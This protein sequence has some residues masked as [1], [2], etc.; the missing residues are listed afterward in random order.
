MTNKSNV[1]INFDTA[2]AMLSRSVAA[3]KEIQEVC[4]NL[5]DEIKRIAKAD[6]YDTGKYE[7][8]IEF[9]VVG[10]QQARRALNQRNVNRVRRKQGVVGKNKFIDIEFQG[11]P[12]GGAYDGSVGLVVSESPKSPLIEFGSLSRKASFPFTKAATTLSKDGLQFEKIFEGQ[13]HSV[14][15]DALGDKISKGRKRAAEKRAES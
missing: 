12:D 7:A 15:L 8:S 14:D 6:A 10:A 9:F 1:S 5:V 11:D 2:W 4:S 13:E 3:K